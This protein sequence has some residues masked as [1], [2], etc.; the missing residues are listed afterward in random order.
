VDEFRIEYVE[1]QNGNAPME[2]FLLSVSNRER[3]DIISMIEELRIR[4][5]NSEVISST[6]S[7]HIRDGIFELRIKHINRIS[8]AFYFFQIGKLIVFT[9]GFIKKTQLVPNSEIEKATK[10]RKIYLEMNQ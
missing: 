10:Y 4:L 7:K 5:N 2:K 8:R 3:A 9:H 6:I 1:L